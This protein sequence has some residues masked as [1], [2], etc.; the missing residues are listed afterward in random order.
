[1]LVRLRGSEADCFRMEY[2]AVDGE[3]LM[4][5]MCL[6]DIVTVGHDKCLKTYGGICTDSRGGVNELTVKLIAEG[7]E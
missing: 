4:M 5:L 2:D 7:R 3:Y 6:C 1:M